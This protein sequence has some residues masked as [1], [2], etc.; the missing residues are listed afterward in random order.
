M[1]DETPSALRAAF[2]LALREA[3]LSGRG[4]PPA[5]EPRVREYARAL[6]LDG[7]LVEKM[8]IDVKSIVRAETGHHELVYVPPIVGW[9]VAGFFAGT[10]PKDGDKE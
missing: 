9:A 10:S 7:V 8:I 4:V 6:R 2:T 5:L 1:P 3:Y